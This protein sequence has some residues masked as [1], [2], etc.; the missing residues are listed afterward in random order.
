MVNYECF[1]CGYNTV[2]KTKMRSHLNRKIIC[3]PINSDI[4]LNICKKVILSGLSFEKYNEIN[5]EKKVNPKSTLSQ[6]KVNPKSTLSQPKVNPKSTLSQHLVNPEASHKN[7]TTKKEFICIFCKLKLSYKQSYYRHLKTCREKQKDD[8][9]RESMTE[10]VNLL[11]EKDKQYKE[12]LD[13]RDKQIGELVKKAGII[14]T[15]HNV[16][17]ITNNIQNN[18]KLLNYKETDTSHLTEN[19]YI[20]CLE[21]Y[22]F[23][24]PHIIRKIHFNPKK[25]E[26]HNIYISNLKN[27]YIMIYMNNKWKVKNRDEI[28]SQMIDDNQILLEKKIHDWVESGEQYPKIMAKFSRYLEKREQNDVINTIK[29]DIKLMLYNNRNMVI[30]NKKI[31]QNKS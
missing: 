1:R 7:N 2:D 25:P 28:I 31:I 23:C 21:H 10:L 27:S 19:D 9:V 20:K 6:P 24:V 15:N 18:I 14:T 16:N 3:K 12:E 29:E 22:N 11:N 4:N 8:T 30:Q 5:L 26:N 13:K 17:H